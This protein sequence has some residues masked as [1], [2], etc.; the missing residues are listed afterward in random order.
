M[1]V[2]GQ[3]QT[4]AV[5][6]SKK[7]LVT[8][9]TGGWVGPRSSLDEYGDEKNSC[10]SLDGNPEPSS[11]EA[12]ATLHTLS[13]AP[14][15]LTLFNG[16]FSSYF[17][18]NVPCPKPGSCLLFPCLC[19][20]QYISSSLFFAFGLYILSISSPIF[21]YN[22]VLSL[23]SP[24][25]FVLLSKQNASRLSVPHSPGH[26]IPTPFRKSHLLFNVPFTKHKL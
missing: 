10:P 15:D 23:D 1:G 20:T 5:L 25:S 3:H 14:N 16:I 24:P 21:L 12:V 9:C 6:P 7:Q 18:P 2:A 4:S 22:S 11:P 13:P 26:N 19:L 8:H 17:S